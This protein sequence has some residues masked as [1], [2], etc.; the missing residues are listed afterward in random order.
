MGNRV[1]IELSDSPIVIGLALSWALA[2]ALTDLGGP[3]L[4]DCHHGLLLALG[5]LHLGCMEISERL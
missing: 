2:G 4:D 5:A 1:T 3:L